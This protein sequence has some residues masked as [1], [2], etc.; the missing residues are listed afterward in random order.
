MNILLTSVGR[1]TYLVNYFK[2]ALKPHN[3][4]VFAANSI[5]TYALKQ[6][7]GFTITPNILRRLYRLFGQ[8]LS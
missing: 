7:D 2:D 6:A 8:L 5:E 1:R 3:G 4:Q